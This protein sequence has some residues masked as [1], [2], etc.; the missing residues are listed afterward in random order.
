MNASARQ[1]VGQRGE[2]IAVQHL[3]SAGYRIEQTNVRFPVGEI[4]IVAWEGETLCFVEV[5]SA[6]SDHWGGPLASVTHR[7]QHR[8]IQAARWC[9]ARRR[10][11]PIETRFD[12]VGICWS[13]PQ[14][15]SVTLVRGA[16]DVGARW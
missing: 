2:A 10:E 3:R 13:N 16:F 8:L 1:R 15:P 9:L 12:V 4:D 14:A 11:L 7:K 5:R 6:S